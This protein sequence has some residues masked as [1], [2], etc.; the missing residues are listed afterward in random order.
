VQVRALLLAL[1]L[2][3]CASAAPRSK[4]VRAEFMREHPCPATGATRGACVGFVADHVEPL[5]AGG[6]DAPQNLQWQ[7]VEE[8]KAKDRL[9]LARCRAMKKRR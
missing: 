5:C 8:A 1:A 6:V 2:T 4:A 9:E 7:S 3:A